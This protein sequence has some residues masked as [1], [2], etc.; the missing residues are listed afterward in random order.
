[1]TNFSA[2]AWQQ[3]LPLYEKIL[4]MP[5][6]AELAAGTLREDRFRHYIIQDA[7]YLEGFA[8][9]LALAAAKADTADQIV[10][11]AEAAR[12]AI[13]VERAL[14]ADY[15]ARFGVTPADFA[16]ARPTPVCDHYVSYLLRVAALDPF[17][18]ALAALL[19]CFWIYLEVGKNIHA[20]AASPNSYQTWIDTY[21]GQEFADAVQAVIATTDSVAT[22]TSPDTLAAMHSAFTRATQLE[23]M[24]WDSAYHLNKWPV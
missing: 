24:F 13:I 3:N 5:F 21:A 6:N 19:P 11:F 1:M 4:A 10:Q 18:V 2:Q 22:R 15:F 16:A 20:R 14:H 8:R 23:W 7:H 12:T 9:A 17:P